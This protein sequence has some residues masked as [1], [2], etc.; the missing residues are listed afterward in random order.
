VAQTQLDPSVLGISAPGPDALRGG[1]AP[2]NAAVVREVL[3]GGAPAVRAAVT[4]NAG[5]AIAAFD[6]L[7]G[8]GTLDAALRAGIHTAEQAIDSGAASA[9]LVEWAALSQALRST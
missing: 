9:L 3:A 4:L 7:G 6:G 2:F 8:P 5:A 1:A